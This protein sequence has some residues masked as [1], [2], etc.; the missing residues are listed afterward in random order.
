MYFH[1]HLQLVLRQVLTALFQ[2]SGLQD[3]PV[4]HDGLHILL[5]K[6]HHLVA[7]TGNAPQYA[8]MTESDEGLPDGGFAVA[9]T[10]D[11]LLFV[12]DLIGFVF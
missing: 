2:E 9:V 1:Q 5:G 6:P 4:I 10:L 7:V 12:Q 3:E 11:E 8:V